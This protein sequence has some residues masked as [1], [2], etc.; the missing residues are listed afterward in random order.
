MD[1]NYRIIE[2]ITKRK[3]Y[4]FYCEKY[5]VLSIKIKIYVTKLS[6]SFKVTFYGR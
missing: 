4:K 3:L 1:I 6:K 2:I 5:L